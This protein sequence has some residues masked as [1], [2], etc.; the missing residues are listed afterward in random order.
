M[1]YRMHVLLGLGCAG[2]LALAACSSSGG[3]THDTSPGGTANTTVAVRSAGDLGDV[4]TD[5]DGKTL[6]ASDEEMNGK[7]VCDT[8]ACLQFWTPLVVADSTPTGP[9]SITAKL[10]TI[11]RPDGKMQVAL[12]GA[13]LYSFSEDHSAGDTKGDNFTDKFGGQSFTWHAATP[14]GFASQAPGQ[15][16]SPSAPSYSYP[17]GGG[18]Y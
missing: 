5:A 3:G 7:I 1:I 16:S 10:T 13:P 14:T 6:Y 4:L 11:A 9:S 12:N 18:G 8:Q 15:P 17:N 2:L